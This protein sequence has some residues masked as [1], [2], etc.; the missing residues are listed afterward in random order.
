MSPALAV[1]PVKVFDMRQEEEDLTAQAA[2]F[3]QYV[4]PALWYNLIVM[5]SLLE[6]NDNLG[7][8]L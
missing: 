2:E 1:Q 7:Q 3:I 4:L 5:R 6:R 8:M